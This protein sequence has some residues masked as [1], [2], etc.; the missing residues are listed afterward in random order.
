MSLEV[1]K[2][3]SILRGDVTFRG[4][5]RE[6]NRQVSKC[7]LME[8]VLV[9]LVLVSMVQ[10]VELNSTNLHVAQLGEGLVALLQLANIRLLSFMRF[11]MGS[12]IAP[13]GKS[14]VALAAL[15]W[16]VTCVSSHV[17]LRTVS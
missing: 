15:E 1:L 7:A 6:L 16:P 12:D 11:L 5:L 2:Q 3:I 14:L 8:V 10:V 17:C 13:L 4:K 9:S